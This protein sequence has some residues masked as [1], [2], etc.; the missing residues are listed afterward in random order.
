MLHTGFADVDRVTDWRGMSAYD[1]PKSRE[2][3]ARMQDGGVRVI[4]RGLWYVSAVH[5]DEHVDKALSVA[6]DILKKMPR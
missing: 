6:R 4:G 3:V 1:M 2:F 5:Q